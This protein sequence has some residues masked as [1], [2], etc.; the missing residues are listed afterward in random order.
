MAYFQYG[1]DIERNYRR[2]D[3][4]GVLARHVFEAP[5]SIHSFDKAYGI[6]RM[7]EKRLKARVNLRWMATY[8]TLFIIIIALIIGKLLCGGSFPGFILLI[9]L[10]ICLT[11]VFALYD[12]F[13]K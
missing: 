5:K 12:F 13:F 8:R 6:S 1:A 7:V 4:V 2:I 3:F 11:F 9:L 10:K